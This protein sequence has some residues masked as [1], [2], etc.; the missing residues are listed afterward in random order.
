[1]ISDK[2]LEDIGYIED[3]QE[4]IVEYKD[5]K[6]Q[7]KEHLLTLDQELT[8]KYNFK[9]MTDNDDI[10]Y[11]DH[12]KG[13]YR[14]NAN[15]IIKQE[16]IKDNPDIK[17]NNV[18]DI[19]NRII[20]SNYMD[21]IDFD[22]DIQWLCFKNVMVNLKT[23]E[24]K[25][26]SPE[27]LATV[28]IPHTYLHRTPHVP[29]PYKILNFLHEV[30]ASPEDVETVLDF[31][32]YCLYRGFPFHKWLL[33]L[34]S[35]RNGKGVTTEL[36]TRFLGHD[37]VS[38]ETL[39]RITGRD[40]ATA[41]LYLKLANIDADLSTEALKE[42][43]TLKKLSGNDWIIA[44]KKFKDPFHFKNF[45]KLIFSANEMPVTP[46]ETDAFFARFI[47][48]NF[49]KQYLGKN[50][51]PYLIE[52]LATE[53]E[54]SSL[55]HLILKRLPR[56]LKY[57]I[58]TRKTDNIIEDNRVKYKESS[59]PIGLF[60]ESCI[61]IQ[62]T[63]SYRETKEAVYNA[64][65]DFCTAKK[66]PKESSETFSRRLKQHDF[67]YEQ[68]RIGKERPYFWVCMQLKDYKEAEEG[69]ETL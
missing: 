42:T 35:G 1:M 32:A 39:H 31:M 52:K 59:D 29:L 58:S 9:S 48:I 61:S 20:W 55:L 53:Q 67:K 50:A 68:I 12:V 57:G 2:E 22:K 7:T 13:I 30:M 8:E 49:P 3:P 47:I 65:Q 23:G 44:E 69:Q 34:G 4:I 43:G 11:Y 38:N 16:C 45:A 18:N 40:F 63:D 28:Q 6:E 10:W 14:N 62:S 51:D 41:S 56:V 26:H 66:L 37:N 5:K 54:M 25:E 24:T 15:W 46:D 21:R 33:F 36:I 27:F 64:Y 60:I 17:T 19:V